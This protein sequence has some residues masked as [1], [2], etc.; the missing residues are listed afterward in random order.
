MNFAALSLPFF[1]FV[2]LAISCGFSSCA[3]TE[4]VP[5]SASRADDI[6]QRLTDSP[7]NIHLHASGPVQALSDLPKS[8]NSFATLGLRWMDGKQEL[9]Y[10]GSEITLLQYGLYEGELFMGGAKNCETYFCL[11]GGSRFAALMRPL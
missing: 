7:T 9:G 1:C 4:D 6:A 10:L 3:I 5:P 11:L 2:S 8:T